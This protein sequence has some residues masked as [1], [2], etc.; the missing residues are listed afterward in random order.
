MSEEEVVEIEVADIIATLDQ[1]LW[2]F[3][4]LYE[5]HPSVTTDLTEKDFHSI[6]KQK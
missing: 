2:M 3:E 5:G 6:K 1:Q 4:E